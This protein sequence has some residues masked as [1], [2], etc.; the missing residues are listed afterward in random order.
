MMWWQCMVSTMYICMYRIGADWMRVAMTIIL[1]FFKANLVQS[2]RDPCNNH[3][4]YKPNGIASDTNIN[5][6]RMHSRSRTVFVAQIFIVQTKFVGR[7][8]PVSDIY[9]Y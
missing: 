3:F 7:W 6:R 9:I 8:S 1:L 5:R 2:A 4:T